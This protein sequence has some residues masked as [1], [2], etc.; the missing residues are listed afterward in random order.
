MYN[1]SWHGWIATSTSTRPRLGHGS[2][3][4]GWKSSASEE[5][6][7]ALR[8]QSFGIAKTMLE[9]GTMT[10]VN[11]NVFAETMRGMGPA[12][13]ANAAAFLNARGA[14]DK[15]GALSAVGR[16]S[17]Q[18]YNEQHKALDRKKCNADR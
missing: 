13:V 17:S 2:V 5:R 4:T 8:G 9:N 16:A 7:G 10:D 1:G 3:K 15:Q 18:S 14:N 12:G 6:A 11:A